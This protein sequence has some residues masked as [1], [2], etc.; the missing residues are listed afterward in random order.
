MV[1][2]FTTCR[3]YNQF[4]AICIPNI[5]IIDKYLREHRIRSLT[6]VV[7]R[8]WAW[9][10]DKSRLIQISRDKHNPAIT[11]WPHCNFKDSFPN[12]AEA[13]P[14]EWAEYL[15][16]KKR[17]SLSGMKP[18]R[19]KQRRICTSCGREWSSVQGGKLAMCRC[20]KRSGKIKGRSCNNIQLSE[21]ENGIGNS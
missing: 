11:Y 13:Y 14:E 21:N 17:M 5:W 20:G 12:A 18:D 10:Y 3:N 7:S 9:H 8:G 6:R 16:K 2:A 19:K 4:I 1:K 15:K